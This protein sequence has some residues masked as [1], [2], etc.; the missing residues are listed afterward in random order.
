VTGAYTAFQKFERAFAQEFLCPWEDLDMFINEHGTDEDAITE[1][2]ETFVVSERLV[3]ATLVNKG[4]A[5][6]NRLQE[7]ASEQE[8]KPRPLGQ[9]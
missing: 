8:I 1:A 3:V 4:K 7:Y 5:S 6:R 2:A 9:S